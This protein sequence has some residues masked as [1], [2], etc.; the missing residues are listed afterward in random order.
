MKR[1]VIYNIIVL[2]VALIISEMTFF[3]MAVKFQTQFIGRRAAIKYVLN[4]YI[5][6]EEYR[7]YD[8]PSKEQR[9]ISGAKY[10][11]KPIILFGCSV[12]YG[13]QLS[14]DEN[15]SGVL[16][17]KTKRPVYNLAQDGWTISHMY[18]HLQINKD[19]ENLDP[20][21]IIY[22]FIPDQKRRLYFHQGWPHDTGLYLSYHYDKN[23]NLVANKRFYPIF[24]RLLTVKYIQ[25][26]IENIRNNNEKATSN[27]MIDLFTRSVNI[28][29]NRYPHAK[30]IMLLYWDNDCNEENQKIIHSIDTYLSEEEYQKLKNLGFE[31]INIEETANKY[32]CTSDYKVDNHH[33]STKMWEE[34]VPIL[35][36][37]Y[38]M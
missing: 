27:L 16:S 34:F 32:Y 25:Y 5:N 1:I 18:R 2:L 8:I 26:E 22:T 11:K 7:F 24:F 31:I 33:P 17:R 15:F 20:E 12:T 29:K 30:L 6:K 3:I 35:A 4:S 28:I 13:N 14:D 19:I 21:Y 36:K 37:K 9:P 10:H 38:K 23:N